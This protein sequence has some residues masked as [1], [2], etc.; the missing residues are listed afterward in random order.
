MEN[1]RSPGLEFGFGLTLAGPESDPPE[2]RPAGGDYPSGAGT[3]V[4]HRPLSARS[5]SAE[6]AACQ[7]EGLGDF[8]CGQ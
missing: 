2:L 3:A 6:P 4:H 8:L 5:S 7:P 1:L